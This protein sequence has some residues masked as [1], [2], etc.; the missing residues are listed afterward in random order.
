MVGSKIERF[1]ILKR[2]KTLDFAVTSVCNPICVVVKLLLPILSQ[3][4][5]CG[6]Y[7]FTK[8]L[9]LSVSLQ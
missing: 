6:F 4:L 5:F 7:E 8:C 3:L 1:V 2:Y 9:K